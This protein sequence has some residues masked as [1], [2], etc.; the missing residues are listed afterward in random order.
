[1]LRG[2]KKS[3]RSSPMSETPQS[4]ESP[5]LSM[6]SKKSK[7][8]PKKTLMSGLISDLP[9]SELSTLSVPK[10]P[11]PCGKA[12]L[13]RKQ[14]ALDRLKVTE[15]QLSAVPPITKILKETPRGKQIALEAMQ[16]SNDG[17]IQQFL[18]KYWRIPERDRASL[19]IEAIAVASRVDA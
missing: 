16:F 13:T 12:G 3:I 9:S 10:L 4:L 7:G 1:M 15:K 6:P 14:A 5:V 17:V 8:R 2:L 18:N 11:R 19:S